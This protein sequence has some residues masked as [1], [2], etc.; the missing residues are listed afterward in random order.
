MSNK[1]NGS[2]NWEDFIKL[3]N[4]DNAPEL[5]DE[6]K[7]STDSKTATMKLRVH[8]EKKGRGGKWTTIVRGWEGSQDA[9]SILG[10]ELKVS[11]GVGGSVKANEIIVQGDQRK[12]VVEILLAKGYKQTKPAGA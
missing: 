10:K 6:K 4:P 3:G 5:P 2:L 7:S 1:N 8:L 9:L 11:C 12:K